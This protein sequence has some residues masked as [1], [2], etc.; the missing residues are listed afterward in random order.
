MLLTLE[1]FCVVHTLSQVD[2]NYAACS[3]GSGFQF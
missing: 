3:A 1:L 2:H